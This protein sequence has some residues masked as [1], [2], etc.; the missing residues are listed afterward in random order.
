MDAGTYATLTDAIRTGPGTVWLALAWL[1]IAAGTTALGLFAVPGLNRV[2]LGRKREE[3]LITH[4]PLHEVLRDGQTLRAK[5]GS[6]VAVLALAGAP[7]GGV[8]HDE[9]KHRFGRREAWVAALG[10]IPVTARLISRR[11]LVSLAFDGETGDP[12]RDAV[13]RRWQRGFQ[14][15]FETDHLLVLTVSGAREAARETLEQA[16]D[17]TRTQLASLKPRRLHHPRS[18]ESDL[19]E[20]FAWLINPAQDLPPQGGIRSGLDGYLYGGPVDFDPA[21]GLIEWTAGGGEMKYGFLVVVPEWGPTVS[22]DLMEALIGIQA[23]MAILQSFRVMGPAEGELKV[24]ERTDRQYSARLS[25]DLMDQI[26]SAREL[27]AQ[28]ATDRQSVCPH[29][30]HVRVLGE[31]P[32]EA[33]EAAHTVRERLMD[34]NRARPLI[35]TTFVQHYYFGALPTFDVRARETWPFSRHVAEMTHCPAEPRGLARTNWGDGPLLPLPTDTG[36][37]Y[38]LQLHQDDGPEALAHTVVVGP[39]G[40]GKSVLLELLMTG[41]SRFPDLRAVAFD[42]GQGMLTWSLFAGAR[43]IAML[44]GIAGQ[45]VGTPQPLQY[46]RTPE[47]LE[48][49]RVFLRMLIGQLDWVAEA[50]IADQV[51]DALDQL[52]QLDR[53]NRTLDA[54]FETAFAG[55]IKA[56]MRTWVDRNQYGSVF[57]AADDQ[58]PLSDADRLMVFDMTQVLNKPRLAGPVGLDIMHRI[59]SLVNAHGCPLLLV[60]DEAHY[61]MMDP[62]FRQKLIDRTQRDRKKRIAIVLVLQRPNSLEE[63]APG[64]T[65]AVKGNTASWLFLPN[66]GIDIAAYDLWELTDRERL[67]VQGKLPQANHMVRPV[68]H[69]VPWRGESA[70]LETDYSALG[71]LR[72]IFRSGADSWRLATDLVTNLGDRHKALDM[73]LEEMGRR[74]G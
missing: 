62:W 43:Y 35:E 7:G 41:A 46:A 63:I 32:E 21:S 16:V 3:R 50:D 28:T 26:E 13:L 67:F 30:L 9:R 23:E 4:L 44:S 15:S 22:E 69:K 66:P 10:N 18:G 25:R 8:S 40:G 49:M 59:D 54:I 31:T 20:I 42:S 57:N 6:L 33:L 51:S 47:N 24:A 39:S 70:F 55:D 14:R 34:I 19:L 53:H 73:F 65:Q 12:V 36:S 71:E 38:A 45:L 11:R 48:H 17:T 61:Y 5:D 72:H 27:V 68:L 2:V 60:V 52:G 37:P 64:L 29:E 56:A 74:G 1:A 58:V